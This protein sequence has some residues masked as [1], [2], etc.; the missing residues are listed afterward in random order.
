[1]PFSFVI[2]MCER[3]DRVK[4]IEIRFDGLQPLGRLSMGLERG[5]EVSTKLA[6]TYTAYSAS[7]LTREGRNVLLPTPCS[8]QSTKYTLKKKKK[9][10]MCPDDPS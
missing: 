4:N 5:F 2:L 6:C 8:V 7:F 10:E 1:L 3:E 9:N